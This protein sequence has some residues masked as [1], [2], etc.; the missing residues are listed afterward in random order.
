MQNQNQDEQEV[1]TNLENNIDESINSDETQENNN[2]QEDVENLKNRLQ[3][4]E[5]DYHNQKIR[6][7]KAESKLKSGNSTG[8]IETSKQDSLSPFDLIAV[9]KANLDEEQLKEAMD[10]AKYKKISISEALKTP[11]VKATIALIEENNKVAQASA[12]G[13]GR[14]G[15]VQISDDLL[16]AN[17]SKGILPESDSD[18]NRLL[19]LR[20]GR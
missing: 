10:Y 13:N 15:S 16:L 2:S 14:R 7:E 17:A 1:L 19:K 5:E 8:R 12:T 18:L 9:A 11:Q 20:R 4:L 6:A 3:K